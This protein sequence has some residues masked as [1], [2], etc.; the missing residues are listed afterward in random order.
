MGSYTSRNRLLEQGT[1]DNTNTWGV[2]Q[3][4]QDFDPIDFALDGW[5][6]LA[7]G[8]NVSLTTA[9]GTPDQARAR[10]L[11]FTGTGSFVVTIPAVEKTYVVWNGCTGALTLTNGSAAVIIPAGQL[12]SVTNDGGANIGIVGRTDFAGQK[13]TSVGYPSAPTDAASK[14]YAD[15]LAFAA[16]AGVLP[17]QTGNAGKVLRTRSGNALWDTLSTA[18]LT[19]YASAILGLQV[20]LA[21]AL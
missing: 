11:R 13:L 5:S 14:Q 19:D 3:S 6:T 21:V 4:T 12:V 10:T 1:G 7:L 18:D 9:N 8:G 15:D 17:G 2:Y 20:A 16:N